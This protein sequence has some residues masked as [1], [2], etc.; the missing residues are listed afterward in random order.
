[1]SATGLEQPDEGLRHPAATA[2]A[3][4]ATEFDRLADVVA[5]LPLMTDEYCFA[6]NWLAS[7]RRLSVAVCMSLSAADHMPAARRE[8][9]PS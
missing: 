6:A 1:M 9:A 7:A 3:V 8:N 2:R 4:I 5:A